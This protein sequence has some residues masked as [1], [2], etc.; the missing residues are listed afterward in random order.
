MMSNPTPTLSAVP[1]IAAA[2]SSGVPLFTPPQT[3]GHSIGSGPANSGYISSTAA[4]TAPQPPQPQGQASV[5][6]VK[7]PSEA[8]DSAVSGVEEGKEKKRRIA[9]TLIEGEGAAP[10]NSGAGGSGT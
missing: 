4:G 9:P 10:P 7:R 5:A 3:P 6:G 1:S 8:A 2:G